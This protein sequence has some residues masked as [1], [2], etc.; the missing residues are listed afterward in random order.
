MQYPKSMQPTHARWEQINDV[1]DND[2]KR[3]TNGH[4]VEHEVAMPTIFAPVK[5]IYS[6]NFMIV[7][8][9]YESA[10]ASNLGVPG[11][12]GD[13]HDLGFNGLA[14]VPDDVKAELPPECLAAFE[15]ALQKEMEWKNRWGTEIEN[16]LRKAPPVDK[17]VV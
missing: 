13:A 3:L 8:T 5:P 9:V 1:E 15:K 17:G 4:M 11:P 7:D 10:P 2:L 6:K 12:D 16:T 14:G